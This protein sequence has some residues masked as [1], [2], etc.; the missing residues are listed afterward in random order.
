MTPVRTQATLLVA[1]LLVSGVA[2]GQSD[3]ASRTAAR[4]HYQ[5]GL[6]LVEQSH[7]EQAL[8]EFRAAYQASPQFAVLYNIGQTCI[9]LGRPV[10]AVAALEQYLG[11]GKLEI[12]PER[13]EQVEKQLTTLKAKTA[14]LAIVT[15]EPGASLELDGQELGRAPLP[16]PVR[17][18]PGDHVVSVRAEDGSKLSRTVKLQAGDLLELRLD[19]PP[20]PVRELEPTNTPAVVDREPTHPVAAPEPHSSTGTRTLGYVVAGLGAGL[21]VAAFGHYLW[22]LGRYDDW[23]TAHQALAGKEDAPGYAAAQTK[24][25]ELASSIEQASRVTVSLAVGSGALVATGVTLVVVGSNGPS[26]SPRGKTGWA[27][28]VAGVW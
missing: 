9:A 14:E 2:F 19:P 1:A 22:N 11:E 10:D 28:S 3:D 4:N 12:P 15:L 7:F 26:P 8:E 24:N 17:V 20:V 18:T 5:Q 25:N 27:L 21:G 23:K 13:R 6:T 16:A